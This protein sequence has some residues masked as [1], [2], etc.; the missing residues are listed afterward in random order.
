MTTIHP[1]KRAFLRDVV[2]L[3]SAG[4]DPGVT[5][6]EI[7]N[8]DGPEVVA[9][10]ASVLRGEDAEDEPVERPEGEPL[11]LDQMSL[12]DIHALAQRASEDPGSITLNGIRLLASYVLVNALGD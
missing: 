4:F 1:D 3:T 6:K 12:D 7:V 10:M 9:F 11:H 8:D 2:L 5:L